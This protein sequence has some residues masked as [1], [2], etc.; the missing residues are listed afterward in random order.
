MV[1]TPGEITPLS[2][3]A[4]RGESAWLWAMESA[5]MKVALLNL[6]QPSFPAPGYL[7][8][9]TPVSPLGLCCTC[10][11]LVK[12]AAAGSSQS[13]LLLPGSLLGW[14]WGSERVAQRA[15]QAPFQ[16]GTGLYT[17]P[18]P[19]AGDS[20]PRGQLS[21]CLAQKTS[22]TLN[23]YVASC[24]KQLRHLCSLLWGVGSDLMDPLKVKRSFIFQMGCS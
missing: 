1:Q 18:L 23:Q 2:P 21:H 13:C 7:S 19:D 12:D 4:P 11:S 22:N 14:G 17:H 10:S 6:A 24:S 3:L 5:A 8:R 16:D 15:F 9:T 20:C